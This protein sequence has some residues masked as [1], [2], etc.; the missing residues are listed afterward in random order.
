MYFSSV[1]FAGDIGEW[2]TTVVI[3][4]F[5]SALMHGCATSMVG[6]GLGL[7][8]FR[9][10][11]PTVLGGVGGLLL[12]MSMHA[13]WNGLLVLEG[14]RGDGILAML[15]YVLFPIEAL[16]VFAAYQFAV[17]TEKRTIRR[18]LAEEAQAGLIPADH[19]EILASWLRRRREGW[20]P[21]GVDRDRYVRTATQ[22]AFRK[23]QARLLGP[24]AEFYND[25][26]D[27]LR[28]AIR[29]LL[30]KGGGRPATA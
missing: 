28:R 11:V 14:M 29:G 25:D 19:P 27:R 18:E 5:Y 1:A 22:L 8:R 30:D 12:A 21:A 4:T 24:T 26:V 6:A 15:N 16:C 23:R 7:F 17:W 10:L 13:T 3:R 9:G 20:V 2:A